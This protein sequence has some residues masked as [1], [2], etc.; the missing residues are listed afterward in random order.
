MKFARRRN[1]K[2]QNFSNSNSR[3]LRLESL[4]DRRLLAGDLGLDPLNAGNPLEPTIQANATPGGQE[5]ARVIVQLTEQSAEEGFLNSISRVANNVRQFSNL[6]VVVMD[7][8]ESEMSSLSRLPN[9]VSVQRDVAVPPA[10]ASSVPVINGDVAHSRG[11]DGTGTTVVIIDTGIDDT[12]NF[13]GTGGSRIIAERCFSN[14]GVPGGQVSLCPNGQATDIQAEV[15]IAACLDGGNQLC[16]HGTHVAGIAAGN[17]NTD[18]T[19]STDY[20]V[21]PV[22]TSLRFKLSRASMIL[23]TAAPDRLRACYRIQVI[24]SPDLTRLP[25]SR[26]PIQVGISPPLT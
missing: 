6:P 7:V 1:R 18:P 23:R 11:F 15:N 3:F 9:V 2:Q 22:P 24:N 20:G 8:P 25:H 10:L 26:R 17:A 12:H 21:A 19:N 14:A 16:D 4:E 13:F 5:T